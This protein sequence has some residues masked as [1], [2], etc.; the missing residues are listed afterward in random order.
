MEQIIGNELRALS[1]TDSYPANKMKKCSCC[2]LDLL[3]TDFNKRKNSKDGHNGSC[4][5][6][7]K[8]R[9]QESVYG[10]GG[11]KFVLCG[12]CGSQ[13]SA[14]QYGS[15]RQPYCYTCMPSV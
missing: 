6:C 7:D 13:I 12:G 14:S 5:K 3:L 15:L 1:I 8:G 11:K 9:Y 2:K 4:R 10:I